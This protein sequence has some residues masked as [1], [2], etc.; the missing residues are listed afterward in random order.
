[1]FAHLSTTAPVD[2]RRPPP[3]TRNQRLFHLVD[4]LLFLYNI[5]NGLLSVVSRTFTSLFINATFLTRLD[6]CIFANGY[7]Y[8]DIG[9][10][11]Y[12]VRVPVLVRFSCVCCGL[13]G[14]GLTGGDAAGLPAA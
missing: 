3:G 14:H 9:F 7:E 10:S 8:W 12:M 2:R 5:V 4:Y 11:C 1:M 13:V 6:K